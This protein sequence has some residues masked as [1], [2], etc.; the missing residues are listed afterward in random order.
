MSAP[1]PQTGFPPDP[2]IDLQGSPNRLGPALPIPHLG[3]K[4][5]R[6]RPVWFIAGIMLAQFGLFVALLAPATVSIQL[7]VQ[8]LTAI[9]AEQASMT[10]MVVTPGALAAVLFNAIGGRLSDRTTSRFGR[11]RPWI[12]L[13]IVGLMLSLLLIALAGGPVLMAVGWFISQAFA[14]VAFAAFLASVADQ[15]PSSQYG[16]TS[17]LIGIAQNAGVMVATWLAAFFVDDMLLLFM[18]PALL[19]VILMTVYA[20]MLPE[21]VLVANRYPFNLRELVATF[22][23]NPLKHPDF[24]LAWWGR[25]LIILASY[26]FITFRLLYMTNHLGLD[27]TTAAAAVA[28]GVTVYTVV[29]MVASVAAGWLS[30]KLGRRKVLVAV[31]ILIFGIGTYGLLHADT[32][33][34]FYVCEAIMGL[35]YGTYVA[36]DL[37]LVLDVLPDREN[38]G[39]DLGVFNMANAL[40]QS[41]APG[42]GGVLLAN[43]GGGTDFTALLVAAAIAAVLGAVITMFIRGVR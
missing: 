24:G 11:R 9:P 10:A 30:D 42:L 28:I 19:G 20:L 25:F 29:S 39:K 40:P 16:K 36:V 41:L 15:L 23:T 35:A 2:T 12:L 33:T 1:T 22:W 7:K 14:N 37:A 5:D 21:P 34:A 38:A 3:I 18:I 32:V 26:L 13:G 6:E 4:P 27:P 31:A 17:G 43:L 8:T